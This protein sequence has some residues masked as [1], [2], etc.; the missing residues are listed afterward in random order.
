MRPAMLALL[1]AI[2]TIGAAPTAAM[3]QPAPATTGAGRPRPTG[4][5]VTFDRAPRHHP[6]PSG[7]WT[8]Y[9]PAR[10]GA[11][12]W[13]MLGIAVALLGVTILLVLRLLRRASRRV[14]AA[15]VVTSSSGS[16]VAR[17]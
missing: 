5:D 16:S 4:P 14:G 1:L 13:R 9:Q 8:G 10:G 3:A 17:S 11:Y 12:R 6:G 7:Y 2:A 15:A